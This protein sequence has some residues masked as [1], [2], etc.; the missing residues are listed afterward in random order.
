MR[1]WLLDRWQV[2]LVGLLFVASLAAL[3]V[4][5]FAAVSLPQRSLEARERLRQAVTEL[6]AAAGP[7]REALSREALA[8][9]PLAEEPN[10]RL[11]QE[12]EGVLG[13]YAGMEGGYYLGGKADQ[14]AGYAHP[15]GPAPPGRRLRRDPPPL[16]TR[17]IRDLARR[18]VYES[19]GPVVEVHEVGP[20]QVA[21]A[22]APVGGPGEGGAPRVAAW[23][24]VRLIDPARQRAELGRYRASAAMALGGILLA[25]VLLANLTRSLRSERT[26]REKLAAELRRSEQLAA[27]G[28]LLAGVAHEVRNPLAAIR[29]TVQLW[30]RLPEQARTPASL[31]AVTVAVDRLNELVSR[32]LL[33]ARG[34]H[35]ERRPVDLNAVV[36]EVLEL[37]RAQAVG[38][39]VAVEE[40]LVDGLPAVHGSAQ[41]LRQVVLNLVTNA[42]QA[43]PA[44]GVLRCET[45]GLAG[46]GAELLV[47]DT[48]PGVAPEARARLFEPFF[49]TRAAGAGL[50]LA[51]CREIVAQHGGRVGLD[52]RPGQP[53][54]TFR[55]FFPL[56]G[57]GL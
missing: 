48:G 43:M 14:F 33:F 18:A 55:V 9:G 2:L 56:S 51:L 1:Q 13:A 30:Q 20:S 36:R 25:G 15:G 21:M 39:G 52:D 54:A 22:A 7:A 40:A 47:S 6:A 34:A 10:R 28:R 49:T 42:L 8:D 46:R 31:D 57:E 23:A 29:S 50:G 24:M 32:L 45:R 5:T 19:A 38:Q 3:L 12:A 44:G 26:R 16:E 37:Y 41:G 17:Y 11:T 27:L 35:E 53:G 4:N